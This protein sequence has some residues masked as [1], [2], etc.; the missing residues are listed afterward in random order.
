MI[1]LPMLRLLLNCFKISNFVNVQRGILICNYFVM[2]TDG[3]LKKVGCI[4]QS[5]NI[6]ST[7]CNFV[8][9]SSQF[10]DFVIIW[11]TSNA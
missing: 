8:P 11:S 6:K 3:H 4:H 1:S 10:L 9:L 5:D 7:A 2:Y